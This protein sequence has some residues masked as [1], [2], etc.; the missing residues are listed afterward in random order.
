MLDTASYADW[1]PFV[2]RAECAADAQVGDP[3]LLHVRWANGRGTTSP[4]RIRVLEAPHDEEGVRRATG[5]RL[6]RPAREARPGTR[7]PI[8]ATQSS[9][10]WTDPLRH[11]RGVLRTAGEAGR[12][13]AGRGR[14]PSPRR[15]AEAALRALTP[16]PPSLRQRRQSA[17]DVLGPPLWRRQ[18]AVDAHS[19]ARLRVAGGLHDGHRSA[20][21]RPRRRQQV[22]GLGVLGRQG[23]SSAAAPLTGGFNGISRVPT[24]PSGTRSVSA[25]SS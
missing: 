16:R 13:E 18:H 17:G 12:A 5:V 23:Q 6:R 10:G 1:N 3:I 7:H 20:G 2:V 11:R 9:A 8:P 14:L 4:E 25:G 15:G 22:P 24:R 21:R 19:D